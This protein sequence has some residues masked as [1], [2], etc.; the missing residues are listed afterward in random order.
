MDAPLPTARPSPLTRWVRG[1]AGLVLVGLSLAAL[2]AVVQAVPR[3]PLKTEADLAAELAALP[4]IVGA[5]PESEARRE[6]SGSLSQVRVPYRLAAPEDER[7]RSLV[8]TLL[9]AH[10]EQVLTERGYVF[11]RAEAYGLGKAAAEERFTVTYC[12]EGVEAEVDYEGL[13]ASRYTVSLGTGARF[14]PHCVGPRP[15]AR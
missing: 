7:S 12:R 15:N 13:T 3:Y 1:G 14:G 8:P 9:R 2:L 4:A 11:Q 6:G 5:V 10:Y